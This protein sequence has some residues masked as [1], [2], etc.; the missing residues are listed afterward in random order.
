MRIILTQS[1][2][3]ARKVEPNDQDIGIGQPSV[4]IC[5]YRWLIT[6]PIGHE[7]DLKLTKWQAYVLIAI[8]ILGATF[9]GVFVC[10]YVWGAIISR[11]GDPDQSLLF[12]YLPI[13][14]LG[15]G[16][17]GVGVLLLIFGINRIR[18]LR[19]GSF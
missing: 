12:W 19:R 18:V 1:R 4:F 15:L 6:R 9:G 5:V 7:E 11:V 3:G 16:A 8:G 14:F 10:M 13:L 2:Q 17:G